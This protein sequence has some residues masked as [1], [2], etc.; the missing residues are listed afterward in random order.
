MKLAGLIVNIHITHFLTWMVWKEGR[1][2]KINRI[3]HIS[4]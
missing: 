1:P 3:K 2:K 4:F